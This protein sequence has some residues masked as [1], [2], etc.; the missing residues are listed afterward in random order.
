[1]DELCRAAGLAAGGRPV[2]GGSDRGDEQAAGAGGKGSADLVVEE[3]EASGPLAESVGGEEQ[4]PIDDPGFQVGG[5]VAAGAE[6]VEDRVEIGGLEH[7]VGAVAAQRLAEAEVGGQVARFVLGARLV[8]GEPA[9]GPLIQPRRVSL[10]AV[11]SSWVSSVW[12]AAM[13]SAGTGRVAAPS[14]Q[15]RATGGTVWRA[16]RRVEPRRRIS[17]SI[18]SPNSP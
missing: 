12:P 7:R 18:G 11:A 17:V 9:G 16:M 13:A 10:D 2:G 4:A 1:V 3:G 5:P 8:M 14:T 6:R 15:M